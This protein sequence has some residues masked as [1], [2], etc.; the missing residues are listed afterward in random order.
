MRPKD[1]H[2]V[3]YLRHCSWFGVASR[4]WINIALFQCRSQPNTFKWVCVHAAVCA[5]PYVCVGVHV[6]D[7]LA[8]RST[9]HCVEQFR[10]SIVLCAFGATT[11]KSIC[12]RSSIVHSVYCL[13]LASSRL[14]CFQ[15][16][17]SDLNFSQFSFEWHFTSQ[18]VYVCVEF[19]VF[20]VICDRSNSD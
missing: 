15:L 20:V 5:T 17:R 13:L 1:P 18:I 19:S 8:A 12:P 6:N 10:F 4:E 2:S 3:C 7:V 9:A 16:N 14:T 11:Q